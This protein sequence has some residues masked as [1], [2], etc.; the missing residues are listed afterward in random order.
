MRLQ[1]YMARCGVA[2]RRAC[3]KLISAGRVEINGE[4]VDELGTSVDEIRD[5]VKVDGSIISLIN[6]CICLVLNKP[7]GYITTMAEQF[8][9][10]CVADLIDESK[11]HGIFPVGR[12]DCDTSGLLLFTNDGDF[13]NLLVHPKYHV[14]KTYLCLVDR[15]ITDEDVKKLEGGVDIGDFVT[16]EARAKILDINDRKSTVEI[17]IH[18]GKNRQ[19]RRMFKSLGFD[20]VELKRVKF[21]SLELG[22]LKEGCVRLLDENEIKDLRECS[23]RVESN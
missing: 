4:I 8:G 16:S 1:K 15:V 9:R 18:E 6:E 13:A 17:V 12:L 22:D 2:S 11:F 14:E 19:V 5:V 20:V 3:E 21:G 7:V 10:P 23:N